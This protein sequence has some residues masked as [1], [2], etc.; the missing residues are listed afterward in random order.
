MARRRRQPRAHTIRMLNT[1][2]VLKQPQ[3]R[4]LRDIGRVAFH[5]FEFAG[6]RPDEPGVLINQPVPGLHVTAGSA[7]YQICDVQLGNLLVRCHRHLS[8]HL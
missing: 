6:N 8:L 3:P 1:V 5:Q 7:S 4:R 2:D